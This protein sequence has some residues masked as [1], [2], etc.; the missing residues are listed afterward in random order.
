VTTL[1][2]RVKSL[3]ATVCLLTTYIQV[4]THEPNN[5][6]LDAYGLGYS[7]VRISGANV[8]I[9]NGLGAT[10]AG[11]GGLGNLVVGYNEAPVGGYQPSER[12]GSHNI[13]VGSLHKYSS[14]GGLVA[15]F[16]NTISGPYA[17]V[18]GGT[19]NTASNQYTSISG[20]RDQTASDTYNTVL[21]S[22]DLT[23][24]TLTITGP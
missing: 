19:E 18:S 9:Q 1:D 11:P 8:L 23:V 24:R 12:L 21:G 3:E 10:E 5:A 22:V 7:Q 20:G 14:V 17:S 4:F 6:A 2:D 15:G 13:I 16:N